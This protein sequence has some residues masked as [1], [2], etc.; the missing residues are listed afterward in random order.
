MNI[1]SLVI[2]GPIFGSYVV[3]V[4][5]TLGWGDGLTPLFENE[6]MTYG[7]YV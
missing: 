6:N 4:N 3:A 7:Y 1:A 2:V 5:N